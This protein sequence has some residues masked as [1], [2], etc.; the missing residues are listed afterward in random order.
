MYKKELTLLECRLLK[1][2]VDKIC[3]EYTAGWTQAPATQAPR[4][5]KKQRVTGG[6][7]AT[8]ATCTTSDTDS[9]VRK[10]PA[11][12][13]SATDRQ[14]RAKDRETAKSNASTLQELPFTGIHV[15]NSDLPS[16][17]PLL[18]TA[19][20]RNKKDGKAQP[21]LAA[22][23]SATASSVAEPVPA[24]VQNVSDGVQIS[25]GGAEK[26][27]EDVNI[28]NGDV[29]Q[30]N[31]G[32]HECDQGVDQYDVA[33]DQG[34]DG[35]DVQNVDA[36]VMAEDRAARE[37][38]LALLLE[39]TKLLKDTSLR[40][41]AQRN[42]AISQRIDAEM[43]MQKRHDHDEQTMKELHDS[44]AAARAD[45]GATMKELHARRE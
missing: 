27:A 31:E 40:H 45:Q 2:S 18:K 35:A 38:A 32:A 14:L 39:Q 3:S 15:Q 11:S 8:T 13:T 12:T 17:V 42:A 9:R 16:Q 36:R 5:T 29:A 22:P 20:S 4:A 28:Q 1:E 43:A 19:G 41:H 24:A 10:A 23:G 21:T 34:N 25:S 30:I 33:N 7:A 37:K 26:Q 6:E 44:D